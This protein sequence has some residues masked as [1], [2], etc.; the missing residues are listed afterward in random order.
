[1]AKNSILNSKAKK[2]KTSRNHGNKLMNNRKIM[3]LT[4]KHFILKL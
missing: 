3:N 4:K 2:N 1:M